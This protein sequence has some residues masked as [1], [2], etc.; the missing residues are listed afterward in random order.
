[1]VPLTHCFSESFFINIICA[2]TFSDSSIDVGRLL[3][4]NSPVM[5][6]LKVTASSGNLSNSCALIQSTVSRLVDKVI[7]I[8]SLVSFSWSVSCTCWLRS[9][10][11]D[12]DVLL[13]RILS[14][15]EMN[16]GSV[17]RYTFESSM[18]TKGN[19]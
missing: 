5:F 11:S 15:I 14:S 7:D 12:S 10:K 19:C 2:P 6:P 3:S 13:V 4:G 16:V 9:D 1:M 18:L 8:L 17:W